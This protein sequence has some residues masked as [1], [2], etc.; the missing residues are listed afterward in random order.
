[1]PCRSVQISFRPSVVGSCAQ[2]YLVQ[3]YENNYGSPI[4]SITTSAPTASF[5]NLRDKQRYIVVVAAGN[6]AGGSTEAR[7]GFTTLPGPPSAPAPAAP[8]PAS[9]LACIPNGSDPPASVPNLSAAAG[10]SP[11]TSV[12][13]RWQKPTIGG[14]PSAYLLTAVVSGTSQT[15]VNNPSISGSA[16]SYVVKELQGSTAYTFSITSLRPG[17]L[18]SLPSTV[19]FTTAAGCEKSFSTGPRLPEG[20]QAK[21][22]GQTVTLSWQ[23]PR[24]GPCASSYS[25]MVMDGNT[26]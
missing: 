6:P 18:Q 25:V 3:V 22:Q 2:N 14:C 24:G 9:V 17:G 23:G 21:A 15:V 8:A 5:S 16:T 26:T 7:V 1:M 11:T 4:Y 12:T 20:I 19:S 10:P 13:L